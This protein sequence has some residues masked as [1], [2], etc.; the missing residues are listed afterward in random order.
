MLVVWSGCLRFSYPEWRYT[1]AHPIEA[2][3][4][5]PYIGK[6]LPDTATTVRA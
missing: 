4:L 6:L 3:S 1:R 5:P 2:V